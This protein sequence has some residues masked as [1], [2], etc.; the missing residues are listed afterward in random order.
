MDLDVAIDLFL[1]YAKIERNLSPNTVESYARDL[2]RFA[3]FC[4]DADV[5]RAE[6]VDARL[7]L[8]YLVHLSQTGLAARSQARALVAIRGLFRHL[9]ADNQLQSDP[10]AGIELPRLSR[11]LPRVLSEDE[12]ERLLAAPDRSTA[13]GLRD[14]AMLETLYASGLRVSELCQLR[15]DAVDRQR[16]FVRAM[17]KGRKQRLVP[18]GETALLTIE[19]YLREA[20]PTLDRR[21]SSFLFLSRLGGALTRQAFYKN[22]GRLARAAGIAR[23]ISPH[24][25]RHSFATHL[26]QRGADLRAVQAMLGHVDIA[27]T[28]IYTH[29]SRGH[30]ARVHAEHH[31]RGKARS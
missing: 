25:L 24:T 22:L 12:V 23:A 2:T 27:T 14:A 10:T 4:V 16:G 20:R 9:R 31:P 26:V 15:N 19:D 6:L 1:Q 3:A 21:R 29:I 17:G 28:E 11:K 8:R 7:L 30:L 18:L 5:T 13:L